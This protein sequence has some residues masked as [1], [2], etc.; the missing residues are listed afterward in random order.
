MILPP[1]SWPTDQG[2]QQQQQQ[3]LE[4][5]FQHG[6]K[7]LL[8]ELRLDIND[9][10]DGDEVVN[11]SGTYP[12]T[13]PLTTHLFIHSFSFFSFNHPPTHSNPCFHT[14]IKF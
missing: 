13:H 6:M 10:D 9:E 7:F 5:V 12:L 11:S 2:R 8:V 3:L 14:P 4:V 1:D